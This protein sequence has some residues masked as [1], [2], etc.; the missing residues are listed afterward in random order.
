MKFSARGALKTAVPA[1][2]L[3]IWLALRFWTLAQMPSAPDPREAL[4]VQ[5]ALAV[6]NGETPQLFN[7]PGTPWTLL[8][9]LLSWLFQTADASRLAGLMRGA[10]LLFGAVCLLFMYKMGRRLGG[11]GLLAAALLALTPSF[12]AGEANAALVDFPALALGLAAMSCAF[13]AQRLSSKRAFWVGALIGVGMAFKWTAGVYA[14]P[15]ALLLLLDDTPQRSKAGALLSAAGGGIVG[16]LAGCPYLLAD[17][18]LVWEGLLYEL[19]HY[20]TGHFALFPTAEDSFFSP[21]LRHAEAFVWAAGHGLSLALAG[22]FCASLIPLLSGSLTK[23]KRRERLALTAWILTAAVPIA[24]HHFS[25]TR[26]WLLTLPPLALLAA[27]VMAESRRRAAWAALGLAAAHSLL[28]TA[29]LDIQTRRPSTIQ[30]CESWIAES[31]LEVSHG[32]SEPTLIW[33]YPLELLSSSEAEAEAFVVAAAE[34]ELQRAVWERGERY[35]ETD[36]FPL[37]RAHFTAGGFHARLAESGEYR[38]AARF[39]A[40][41]PDWVRAFLFWGQEPPF[42]HNALFHPEL[43]VYVR[44]APNEAEP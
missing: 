41:H 19:S 9:A 7:W 28:L 39:S 1:A 38:M 6:L 23:E 32:P 8:S 27:A 37:T 36:F 44:N 24:L 40:E 5:D 17:F 18:P 15:A 21:A 12:S 29:A 14:V 4:I 22:V 10:S 43:R 13:S 2:A 33:I 25:F 31:G 30:Q 11:S 35:R 26:H 42:P 3:T 20:N 34:A 16:I